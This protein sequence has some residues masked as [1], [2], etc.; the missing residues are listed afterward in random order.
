M[1]AKSDRQIFHLQNL[2]CRNCKSVFKSKHYQLHD[3]HVSRAQG[4]TEELP[5]I[6]GIAEKKQ[7][8]QLEARLLDSDHVTVQVQNLFN[9]CDVISQRAR[10]P[11]RYDEGIKNS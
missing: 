10:V 9:F 11:W 3:M 2:I 6:V 5:A 1:A 4:L 8:K 7:D